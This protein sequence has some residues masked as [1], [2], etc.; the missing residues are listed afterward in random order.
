M[1]LIFIDDKLYIHTIMKLTKEEYEYLKSKKSYQTEGF[2]KKMFVKLLVNKLKNNSNFMKAIDDADK[3]AS[4]L[5]KA[6]ENAE[7]TGV[8]VPDGLKKYAG[9]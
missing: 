8:K 1:C 4:D 2:V 9:L 3:A 6:I 7:K 5:R